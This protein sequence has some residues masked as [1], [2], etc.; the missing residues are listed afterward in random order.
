VP[1]FLLGLGWNLTFVAGS[2]LLA[3]DASLSDRARLQGVTDALIWGVAAAASIASG[4]VVELAG[5]V[6]LSLLGAGAA[7]LLATVIAVDRRAARPVEA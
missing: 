4:Y 6:T 7:V 5:Y 2:S 1:L 3:S